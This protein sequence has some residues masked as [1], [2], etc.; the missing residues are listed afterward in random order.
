M[1]KRDITRYLSEETVLRLTEEAF[2]PLP[3]KKRSAPRL[4]ALAACLA[5]VVL[6]VNFDTVYAAV[7]ELLYFLPGSGPVGQEEELDY[8]LPT[9]EYTAKTEGGD[10]FVTCLYRRGDTLSLRVEKQVEGRIEES[11]P[12]Q[13]VPIPPDNGQGEEHWEEVPVLP[14]EQDPDGV[15]T[16]PYSRPAEV[17]PAAPEQRTGG[18]TVTFRDETGAVLDLPLED[19]GSSSVLDETTGEAWYEEEFRISDFTWDRFTLTLDGTVEFLV[20]LSPINVE[21]YA[22]TGSTTMEDIGYSLT[23]LPLNKNCTRFAILP[24]PTGERE[25]AA[26]DGSY[27]EALTSGLMAVGESGRV[28]EVQRVNS[29]PGCQEFW[30][31]VL[32]GERIVSVTVTG[33][34]ESTRYEK[35]PAAVSIP[36]LEPGE[37]TAL[38]QRLE[39]GNITLLARAAGLTEEGE[40]WVDL[41]WEPE[42]GRR[43]NQVDF[44]WPEPPKGVHTTLYQRTTEDG[45]HLARSEMGG[46]AG[47]RVRLPVEF[48]SLVQEGVWKLEP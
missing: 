7:R 36:A 25:E 27:W 24:A 6:A 8:W 21:D 17:L 29:R 38:E 13:Q 33:I 9:E 3:E 46:T 16:L 32:P 45:I 4:A 10:Y 43:L 41:T 40:L 5:L 30:L 31:P 15:V 11:R 14:R 26:P 18:I 20:E 44:T 19:H 37:E 42:T 47:K 2:R 28:Y 22:L 35:S 12:Y 1:E 23:L 39:L 48:V 34:L